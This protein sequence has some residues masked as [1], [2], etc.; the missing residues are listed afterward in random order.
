VEPA[1][2]GRRQ[3]AGDPQRRQAGAPQD[4]VG[5]QV[6]DPGQVSLV[7]QPGFES[8][9]GAGQRAAQLGQGHSQR[10]GTQPSLVR[11]DLDPAQPS[12]VVHDQIA[13][14]GEGHREPLEPGIGVAPAVQEPVDAG[15]TVDEQPAAHPE[16]QPQNGA[17]LHVQHQELSPP[18]G[19]LEATAGEY[20]GD[21]GFGGPPLQVPGVRGANRRHGPAQR[22]GLGQLA[23]AL[24]LGQLGHQQGN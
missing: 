17:V 24:D 20:G 10:V 22:D 1:H 15:P 19:R 16:P 3:L 14:V 11:I 4:L 2:G 9:L 13:A 8:H 18:P 23:V 6:P 7:E 21:L 5:D 12:G